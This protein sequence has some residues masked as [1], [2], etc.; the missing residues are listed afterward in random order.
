[1]GRSGFVESL[2]EEAQQ[3]VVKLSVQGLSSDAIADEINSEYN[4]N[5]DSH[6]V[7][8]FLTRAKKKVFSYAQQ[9]KNYQGKIAKSWFD[10]A[11][12]LKEINSEL[13][14][15]FLK[16]KN[17]PEYKDKII[18]CSCGKRQTINIQSYGLLLKTANEILNTIKH[19]D[20]VLGR[21]DQAPL[22]VEINYVD[23]SQKLQVIMP[24]M[25]EQMKRRGIIKNYNKRK[26]V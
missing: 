15:F 2:G 5:F 25:L 12:Q 21:T 3:K 4:T 17:N 14:N 18:T 8:E 1:M 13:W 22:K 6:V 10:S 11:Q 26:F 20:K 24:E 19:L 16:I 23:L 7:K 9:D